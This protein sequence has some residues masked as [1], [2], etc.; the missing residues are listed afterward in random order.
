M[1]PIPRTFFIT[2]MGR[3]GTAYLASVLGT[4][5]SHRVV[6]EWKIPRTRFRDGRLTRFP[7]WRFYLARHPLGRWRPGYGEVNSHLRRTLDPLTAGPEARVERRG[8]IVRDP[9]DIIPSVMNRSGRTEAD[10]ETVCETVLGWCDHIQRLV[11]HPVLH[12]ER[13]EFERMTRDPA[14][15]EQI[16]AWAGIEGLHV[17]RETVRTRVNVNTT[18]WFPPRARWTPGQCATFDRLAASYPA[19]GRLIASLGAA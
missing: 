11:E 17:P 14:Y 2:G 8:V 9:R 6:H 18:D 10:F 1:S 7:L 16:A 12:Y 5:P 15:V 13:F 19:A 4:A 3:S